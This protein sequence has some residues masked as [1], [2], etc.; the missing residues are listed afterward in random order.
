MFGAAETT[1]PTSASKTQPRVHH[2]LD[3]NGGGGDDNEQQ[4]FFFR[5]RNGRLNW[6]KLVGVDLERVVRDVSCALNLSLLVVCLLSCRT[7]R[8]PFAKLKRARRRS[9][10]TRALFFS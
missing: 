9:D 6:R 3:N 7:V 10:Q 5:H 1:T 8:S 2:I 4:P